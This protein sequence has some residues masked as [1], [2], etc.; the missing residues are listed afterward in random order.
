[1]LKQNRQGGLSLTEFLIAITIGIV[2]LLGL[3][4]FMANT[5]VS[6]TKMVMASRLNQ[7]MRAVMTLVQRDI[8]RAGFWGSPTYT[9]GALAGIGVGNAYSNPFASLDTATAGCILYRYDKNSNGVA[10]P[11]ESSGFLR[12]GGSILMYAGTGTPTCAGG[13][14]WQP[15]TDSKS[16]LVTGLTFT[17]TNSPPL[18]VSATSGPNIK[19]RY[20]TIVLTAGSAADAGITQTLRET[21][22]LENDLFSPG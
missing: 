16:T 17:Q 5:L 11:G 2:F 12:S 13:T 6:D 14:G 22:K 15:L 4:T 3:T 20:V 1:M 9:T 7:E 19:V 10:D 8:R 18:Y 21:V